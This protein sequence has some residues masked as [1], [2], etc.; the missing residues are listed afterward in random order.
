MID[1]GA[2]ASVIQRGVLPSMYLEPTSIQY[3]TTP[4]STLV[5]YPR[6][7]VRLMLS[8]DFTLECFMVEA[9]LQA[10]NAQCLIGC[11]VLASGV[12]VYDGP[13]NHF[14]LSL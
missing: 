1:T 3:V 11:D 12:L 7:D 2:Q 10:W 5:A 13:G 14:S 4:S 9:P 8:V 6:Y